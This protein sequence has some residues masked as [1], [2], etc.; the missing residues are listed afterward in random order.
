M[1]GLLLMV[2]GDGFLTYPPGLAKWLILIIETAATLAIG[3]ARR[4]LAARALA[5]GTSRG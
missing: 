2:G 3:A 5:E 1:T 4:S